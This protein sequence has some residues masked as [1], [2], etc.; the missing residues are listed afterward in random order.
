MNSDFI[1][2]CNFDVY[3]GT[4]I[5]RTLGDRLFPESGITGSTVCLICNVLLVL[6]F[7][8]LSGLKTGVV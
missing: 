8:S 2:M 7:M 1:I 4:C 6:T 5:M 3:S